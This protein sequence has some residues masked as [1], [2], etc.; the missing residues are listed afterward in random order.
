MNAV[1]RTGFVLVSAC[2]LFAV[3]ASFAFAASWDL[4]P[5][6]SGN[7]KV[8]T[9]FTPG[10]DGANAVAIQ[11][12]GKVVVVGGSGTTLTEGN[13]A[14]VRYNANGTLDATF[15]GNGKVTTAFTPGRDVANA[16]AIQADGKIVAA[17][18]ASGIGRTFALARYNANGTLDATF[19]G[20]GTV[21][22][23]F[24]IGMDSA[25]GVVV[26]SNGKI[27]AAGTAYVD[28]G[29]NKFGL[30]RY[31]ANGT[32]DTAFGGDGKV[33]TAFNGGAH[34]NALALQGGGK[35]VVAGSASELA[36]FA[37]ARYRPDGTLDTTFSA[38]GKL[39]TRMGRGETAATGVAI[40]AN[41]KVVAAGYT[42]A[43]HE[44]GD[45][46]GPGKFALARYRVDGTL[47]PGFGGD[48]RVKTRFGTRTAAANA[49]AIQGN[50]RIVATGTARRGRLFALARYNLDGS[51]DTTFSGD[52]RV[53]TNFTSGADAARGVAVRAGGIVCAGHAVG[54]GGRFAV[55]RYRGIVAAGAG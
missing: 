55:S 43:P 24:S 28:C 14:L 32:L 11:P 52:G 34:A 42:D 46:F 5:A 45:T 20:D 41:G 10:F 50:G 12:N 49:V 18:E 7:G 3:W 30:V 25:A 1:R 33:T 21:M 26:Q 19:G 37:L 27:V 16:V 13:F 23:N 29:C 17:G 44:F 8:M 48:G 31:N 6:F 38:N 9:N 36:W 22:T 40:Q 39:T 47:D 2:A 15:G 53:T 54:S 35:L 4:D 51:R